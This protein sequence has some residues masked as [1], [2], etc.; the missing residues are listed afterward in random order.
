MSWLSPKNPRCMSLTLDLDA[1]LFQSWLERSAATHPLA[2]LRSTGISMQT[3]RIW[4]SD[5]PTLDDFIG[6]NA[7]DAIILTGGREIILSQ[8]QRRNSLTCRRSI[9][10]PV[11]MG[12]SSQ[13]VHSTNSRDA[14]DATCQDLWGVFRPSDHCGGFWTTSGMR[15]QTR[16]GGVCFGFDG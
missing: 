1:D 2:I 7:F 14:R 11:S 9:I 8:K 4:E 10:R 5:W 13:N 16:V 12:H 15:R 3:Y 6:H